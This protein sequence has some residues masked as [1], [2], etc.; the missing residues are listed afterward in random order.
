[1]TKSMSAWLAGLCVGASAGAAGAA[2]EPIAVVDLPSYLGTWYDYNKS[3][4]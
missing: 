4:Y 2:L 3:S 1:M